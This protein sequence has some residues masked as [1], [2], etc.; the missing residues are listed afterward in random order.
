MIDHAVQKR[1]HYIVDLHIDDGLIV[2][3][4][5]RCSVQQLSAGIQVHLNFL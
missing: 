5:K 1:F 2:N 3:F 4:A